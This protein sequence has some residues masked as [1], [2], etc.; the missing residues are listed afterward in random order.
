MMKNILVFLFLSVIM[1]LGQVT[2]ITKTTA[3]NNLTPGSGSVAG[4]FNLTSS[5]PVNVNSGATLS[6]LSGGTLS[7]NGTVTGSAIGSSLQPYNA[8][9]TTLGNTF[10]TGAGTFAQGN[11]TR[12]P[13]SVTGIRKS[14][15]AGSTDTA[16]SSSDL[17]ATL[18]FTLD[19]T[20]NMT[21][22]HDNSH[23]PT[24]L[25][26]VNF[27]ANYVPP[28][29]GTDPSFTPL[30][31]PSLVMWIDPLR[32]TLANGTAISSGS[33]LVDSSGNGNNI[34]TT[35]STAPTFVT[36]SP[37]NGLPSISFAGGG[38]LLPFLLDSTTATSFTAAFVIRNSS[39][40][41]TGD[42]FGNVAN[43]FT[44]YYGNGGG[45]SEGYLAVGNPLSGAPDL[46][47]A[48]THY[49]DTGVVVFSYDGSYFRM[50]L[51][52]VLIQELSTSGSLP[53]GQFYIG[54]GGGGAVLGENI[55]DILIYK[56]GAQRQ[57]GTNLCAFLMRKYN[58]PTQKI[59]FLGDSITAS[60][61]GGQ[62]TGFV[63]QILPL[64]GGSQSWSVTNLG[65]PG[66]TVATGLSNDA[67]KILASNR[68]Q[69]SADVAIEWEQTNDVV[70][71]ATASSIYSNIAARC[72]A[73]RA[74]GKRVVVGTMLPQG[75]NSA[76]ETVRQSLNAMVLAGWTGFADA[77]A[78]VGDDPVMGYPGSQSNTTYYQTASTPVHPIAAGYTVLAPTFANAIKRILNQPVKLTGTLSS[79]SCTITNPAI[80]AG[81]QWIPAHLCTGTQA[82]FGPLNT[83]Q[84]T[85]PTGG[86]SGYVIVKSSSVTDNDTISITSP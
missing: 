49:T 63:A 47:T 40:T 55:G 57:E 77:L 70:S 15:G 9:T 30:S 10:G 14:A 6:L 13:A 46:F 71:G 45:L 24:T 22:P 16:A 85:G 64:I 54:T 11:D 56:H 51:N 82:T 44:L 43:T 74:A 33:P 7:L 59:A 34:T 35:F 80:L 4:G 78:D 58:F 28:I 79:G 48:Y 61:Y 53:S 72:S 20:G 83:Y 31:I 8:N 17:F 52:G 66:E 75:T 23:V 12:F 25:D 60:I 65:I 26:V 27:V 73:L 50:W 36:G 39:I 81:T 21:G 37:L 2:P 38:L 67:F 3:N 5:T 32:Q 69:P 41:A 62:G 42:V 18:A 68:G 19:T 86:A 29:N 76:Q 1:A 84:V